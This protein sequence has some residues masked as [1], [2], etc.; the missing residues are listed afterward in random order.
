MM[1]H[2]TR[3]A[4][5]VLCSLLLNVVMSLLGFLLF[6][7]FYVLGESVIVSGTGVLAVKLL[8]PVALRIY[9][10]WDICLLG[11][12]VVICIL[13]GLLGRKDPILGLFMQ[14]AYLAMLVI[15][16]VWIT[17][18]IAAPMMR[19]LAGLKVVGAG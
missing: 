4:K 9:G 11:A 18:Q 15:S 10:D 14:Y 8:G 19:L 1:P 13:S 3:N 7:W 17:G 6:R 12:G 5:F 16:F 2:L